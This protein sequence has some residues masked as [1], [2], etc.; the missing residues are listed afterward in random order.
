MQAVPFP[1]TN[2]FYAPFPQGQP[3]GALPQGL[4]SGALLAQHT[5][6]HTLSPFHASLLSDTFST[7][8]Q[9]TTPE[10]LPSSGVVALSEEQRDKLKHSPLPNLQLN[11]MQT[12]KAE[13][14]KEKG[15]DFFLLGYEDLAIAEY[16]KALYADPSYTDAYYNL[17]RI[18]IE[19]KDSRRAAEVLE[20]LLKI[21]PNDLESRV[22]LAEQL[23]ADK[24]YPK[25]I[26]QYQQALDINPNYDPASRGQAY[27]QVQLKGNEQ[28]EAA[29]EAF[30][31]AAAS[32]LKEAKALASSFLSEQNNEAGL[33]LLEKNLVFQ[34]TQT[35]HR[36]INANLAEYDNTY[37]S[38]G[39][40]RIRPELAFA[41]PNVLACYLVHELVHAADQDPLSSV[42]EEQDA[43]RQQAK[44][45]QAN[46]GHTQDSNLDLAV[47][48]YEEGVDLLDQEV[49]RSYGDDDLLPEKSPGHGLPKN[50]EALL[51]YEQ[52]RLAKL[53][54]Y[55]MKRIKS[56]LPT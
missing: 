54:S 3:L 16:M 2:P 35:E 23:V 39:I 31:Q 6:R 4:A 15:N 37:G 34:F 9:A 7:Q 44:F 19:R 49:R 27:L 38:H 1:Q 26:Q 21:T 20:R 53:Q 48:L 25:A 51:S 28:P 50:A 11:T 5:Y 30:N 32:N 12:L 14:F 42:M 18:Y 22:M 24:Q 13:H 43:Y 55:Q 33:A 10:A 52:A 29:K 47:A 56:L 41:A 36:K 8:R 40:I 46:K 45:W 17:S